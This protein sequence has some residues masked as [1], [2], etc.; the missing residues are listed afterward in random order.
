MLG[1]SIK[2]FLLLLNILLIHTVIYAQNSEVDEKKKYI[3]VRGQKKIIYDKKLGAN[4]LLG[5]VTCT[6]QEVVMTC[7]SAWLY[8]NNTIDAF[9]HVQVRQGDS[10]YIA[11]DQLRY[12]GSVRVAVL[13]GNVL[14]REKDMILNTS[15]LNYDMKSSTASYF[16]GATIV[17]K[18]NT[19]KSQAGNYHSPSKMLSF[20]KDVE[21]KNPKYIMSCDTLRYNIQ[22][23][24][25]FFIGPSTI[26]SDSNF[27]YTELGSYNTETENCSLNKNTLIKSKNQILRGDS[28]FYNRNKR[29]GLARGNVSFT[30]T[31]GEGILKG[32]KAEYWERGELSIISG[33]PEY[34]HLL[35]KDTLYIAADTFYAWSDPN[36]KEK[37]LRA[38]YH[39]RF[40]KKEMQGKCDSI[41]YTT[42]DSSMILHHK[43]ILWNEESQITA[44]EIKLITGKRQLKKFE[45]S[46]N[47][48]IA[49][50][51]DS[52]SFDQISGKFIEGF[53]EK[54]SLREIR[55]KGNVQAIYF[56]EQKKKLFAMNKT[57]CNEMIM[58]N[59]SGKKSEIS[60]LKK[61]DAGIYPLKDLKTD[62]KFLKGFNWLE[63]E[64]PFPNH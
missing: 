36:G 64:K 45:I 16:S 28:I 58:R 10:I 14:C 41:T 1:S 22:N 56:I 30:D 7:D 50:R 38:W 54:D 17:N 44:K 51:K 25:A 24:T 55:I 52:S 31:T 39:C 42:N 37:I 34:F 4:R 27:I 9:G 11:A 21:L 2:V 60:F 13:Q 32:K 15:Q 26:V 49:S 19:L 46:E 62:N 18:E 29:Y 59:I 8:D 5:G 3:E 33:N 53:F 43:P 20:R 61:P 6:H 12:D 57:T 48:F 40:L 35:K 23:K 47:A 63:K